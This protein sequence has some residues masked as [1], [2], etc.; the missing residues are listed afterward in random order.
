[1]KENISKNKII[2][3]IVAVI[4][5]LIAIIIMVVVSNNKN[6]NNNAENEENLNGTNVGNGIVIQNP[7]EDGPTEGRN[8]D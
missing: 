7:G 4:V 2:V 3:G 8:L 5:I 6:I 1:M